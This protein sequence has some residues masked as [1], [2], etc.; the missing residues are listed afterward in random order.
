M[1]KLAKRPKTPGITSKK[2][3]FFLS[4][5]SSVTTDTGLGAGGQVQIETFFVS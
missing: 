3:G 1:L 4:E 5:F 2:H